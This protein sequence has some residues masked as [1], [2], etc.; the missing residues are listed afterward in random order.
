MIVYRL[1]KTQY[2]YDLVGIGAKLYGARWNNNRVAGNIIEVNCHP[3]L[4]CQL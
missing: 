1:G 2:N 4:A 3:N